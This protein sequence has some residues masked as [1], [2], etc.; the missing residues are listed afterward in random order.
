MN[1]N[2]LLLLFLLFVAIAGGAWA[3]NENYCADNVIENNLILVTSNK[4]AFASQTDARL[5]PRAQN[6]FWNYY[7]GKSSACWNALI[8]EGWDCMEAAAVYA[9]ATGCRDCVG[10]VGVYQCLSVCSD[11][12]NKCKKAVAIGNCFSGQAE[13]QCFGQ[14]GACSKWDVDTSVLEAQTGLSSGG[15]G[16]DGN[17]AGELVGSGASILCAVIF[18]L[19]LAGN[20]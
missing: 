9:G 8:D 13:A 1:S 12:N 18:M 7:G 6:E 4:L 11:V 20:A 3:Q 2:Y 19:L 10:G 15:G 14:E 5:C 17:S 16:N